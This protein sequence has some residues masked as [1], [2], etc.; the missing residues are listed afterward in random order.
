MSEINIRERKKQVRVL[1]KERKATLSR[2]QKWK[3]LPGYLKGRGVA[4]S[5]RLK[6]YWPTGRFPMKFSRTIL[7]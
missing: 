6:Q 3:H 4:N 7:L 2:D 1:I 5:N